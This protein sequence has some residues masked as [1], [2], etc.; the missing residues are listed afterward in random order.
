MNII[1]SQYKE[2]YKGMIDSL[3]N[4]DALALNCTLIY[5][6]A[7]K[8]ECANCEIDPLSGRSANISKIE[9]SIPFIDGQQCPFCHGDGYLFNKK[10]E[11]IKLLILFDYKYWINFNTNINVQ[12][13][14]IQ[15]INKLDILNKIKNTN[16]LIV[17]KS[18]NGL[19]RN[20]FSRVSDPE[21][22]GLGDNSYFF[23][24]WR[25]I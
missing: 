16:R 11:D 12:D 7:D 19:T 24:F 25:K 13:G 17:D 21:P 10:E 6:N 15:T 22:A 14:M 3:F 9:G 1:T 18:L 23:T 5:E 20:L 2:L 4:D 8:I